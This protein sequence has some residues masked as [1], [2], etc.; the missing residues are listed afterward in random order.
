MQTLLSWENNKCYITCV[1][2]A[3]VMQHMMRMRC[4]ILSSVDSLAVQYFRTLSHKKHDFQKI[5]SEH[6][7]C[8]DILYNFRLKCHSF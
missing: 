2:V 6:K 5:L 7:M 1:S 8:S 3:L 4:I